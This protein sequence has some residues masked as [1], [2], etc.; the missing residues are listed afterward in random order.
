MEFVP[1]HINPVT[2]TDPLGLIEVFLGPIPFPVP[3]SNSPAQKEA[4]DNAVKA[5]TKWLNEV[6][7]DSEEEECPPCNPPAGEKYN[8]DIHYQAHTGRGLNDGSHGCEILTGNPTHW[9]YD[10]NNQN[11]KTC[12][13][14]PQE[15]VFGGCGTP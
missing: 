8:I 4:N 13:C 9:H 3:W 1:I 10:V 7:S 15:H 5:L 11:P 2:N 6:F 14:Y 12:R